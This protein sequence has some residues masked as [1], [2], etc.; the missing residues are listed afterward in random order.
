MAIQSRPGPQDSET[1]SRTEEVYAT[2]LRLFRDKGYDATSIQDIADA[3]GL[4]K[5]SLYTY[6]NSK[7]DLLVPIFERAMGALLVAMER[8][9]EDTS[10]SPTAQL[11]A[12]IRAHVGAVAHDLDALSVYLSEWR[13]LASEWLAENRRQRERYA[14]LLTAIIARGVETGELRPA[15]PRITML[16]IVG[17]C[18]WLY[19]WYRPGGRFTPEE[20]ADQF[21]DLILNGLLAT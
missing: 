9:A 4:H 17:M 16:A 8:I 20:I 1:S 5:S 10:L 14:D 19:R 2:A 7:E 11:R 15:D 3:L 12:A 21:A 18:N 13:K 6:I